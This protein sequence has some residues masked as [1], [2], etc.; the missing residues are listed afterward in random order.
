VRADWGAAAE[1]RVGSVVRVLDGLSSLS[2]YVIVGRSSKRSGVRTA[3][4]NIVDE[5][6]VEVDDEPPLW[7]DG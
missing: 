6:D 7:C 4:M 2:G 3:I 5:E 1:H